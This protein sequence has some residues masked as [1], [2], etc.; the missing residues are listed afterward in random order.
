LS[1]FASV[2]FFRT[3]QAF[4]YSPNTFV[5]V[6]PSF[7]QTTVEFYEQCVAAQRM[8]PVDVAPIKKTPQLAT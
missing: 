5:V 7:T 6:F 4:Q 8:F 2:F 3:K 1:I